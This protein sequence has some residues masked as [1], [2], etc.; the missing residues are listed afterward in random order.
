VS[1]EWTTDE[2]RAGGLRASVACHER[3]EARLDIG[4]RLVGDVED[5]LDDLAAGEVEPV[6]Y[7]RL[8][9]SAPPLGDRTTKLRRG[10]A[11]DTARVGGGAFIAGRPSA[12]RRFS[13][14]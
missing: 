5:D 12:A 11:R 7:S 6:P 8:T 1:P 13:V 3:R 10:D 4:V 14:I 2:T 9:A